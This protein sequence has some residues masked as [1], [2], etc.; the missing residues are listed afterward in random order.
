MYS[1][2]PLKDES[3][4]TH[5][6]THMLSPTELPCLGSCLSLKE[7]FNYQVNGINAILEVEVKHG[8][9]VEAVGKKTPTKN[10][11][12]YCRGQSY[13]TFLT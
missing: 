7:E 5:K 11:Q 4:Y 13:K 8:L 12:K 9:H 2:P 1:N 6:H 3:K 10:I